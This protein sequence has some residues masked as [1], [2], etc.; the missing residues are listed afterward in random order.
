ML[1][2][3]VSPSSLRDQ[4]N[5]GVSLER[6]GKARDA[7]NIYA[8]AYTRTSAKLATPFSS[9]RPSELLQ[10]VFI[11]VAYRY[12][13]FLFNIGEDEKGHEVL[14]TL[15]RLTNQTAVSTLPASLFLRYAKIENL[16]SR[17]YRD[18][19]QLDAAKVTGYVVLH[20]LTSF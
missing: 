5:L 4:Y 19:K 11:D 2:S 18:L 12:A 14:N 20:L 1:R 3:T 7:L 8:V 13:W 9:N 17:Y 6:V 15:D 16:K 10:A